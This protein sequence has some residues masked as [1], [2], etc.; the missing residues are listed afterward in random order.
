M[1]SIRDWQTG[2]LFVGKDGPEAGRDEFGM[3]VQAIS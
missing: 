2:R 1:A 3:L